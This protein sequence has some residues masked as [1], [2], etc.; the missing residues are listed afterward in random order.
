M[1]NTERQCSK[2]DF[3][4][5]SSGQCR[6]MP[7]VRQYNLVNGPTTGLSEYNWPTVKHDDW[8]GQFKAKNA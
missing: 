1:S 2:C 5:V 8:C 6:A 4:D 7:P 3:Y